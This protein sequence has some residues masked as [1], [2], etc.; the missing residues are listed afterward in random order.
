MPGKLKIT[1][2]KSLSG[3]IQKHIRT[4]EALGLRRIHHS[5]IHNDTPQ[6]RGMIKA[7]SFMLKVEEV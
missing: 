1:Q 3:R 5:V 4:S 2:V 6:I 7:V